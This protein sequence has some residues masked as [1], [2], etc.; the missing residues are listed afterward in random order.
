MKNIWIF[1]TL[2]ILYAGCVQ[3]REFFNATEKSFG[4]FEREI[5]LKA[6]PVIFDSL[7]IAPLGIHYIEGHILIEHYDMPYFYTL[8]DTDTN[9]FV[10]ELIVQGRGPNEFISPSYWDDSSIQDGDRWIYMSDN[11][12]QCIFK[13][14]LTD[15]IESG[16]TNTIILNKFNDHQRISNIVNDSTFIAF[17]YGNNIDGIRTFYRKYSS[18]NVLDIEDID[19]ATIGDLSELEMLVGAGHLR[20]DK[21]KMVMAMTWMN[22]VNIID[23]E[24]PKRNITL[25]PEGSVFVPPSELV[26]QERMDQVIHYAGSVSTQDY[27]FALYH[28]QPLG[29][30]QERPKEVEISVFDWKGNPCYKLHI[31]EYLAGFCIDTDNKAMYAFDYS[32]NIYRYDLSEVLK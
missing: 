8:Y 23:L 7:I 18:K 9:S 15:F 5:T 25:T 27:I 19:F 26:R 2:S 20:P 30:W 10:G 28:N 32:D 24:N 16:A 4:D 13:V 3:K 31:D 6:E 1:I 21:K 11:S 22:R 17:S 12:I 29:E 14:N